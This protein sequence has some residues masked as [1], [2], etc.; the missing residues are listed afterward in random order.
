MLE[1]KNIHFCH[2]GNLAFQ[3][4][5]ISFSLDE[6]MVMCLL[7][8][9]GAGKT[10]LLNLIFGSL[11]K[12][13]GEIFIHQRP[14]EKRTLAGIRQE[15]ALVGEHQ[16]CFTGIS[17]EENIDIL[18]NLYESFDSVLFRKLCQN[19]SLPESVMHK[20]VSKLSTGQAKNWRLRLPFQ[21]SRSYFYWMNPLPV[22]MQ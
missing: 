6:G 14:L 8:K 1:V 13:G 12:R 21:E 19:L 17:I 20:S 18:S 16:W 22:W 5:N 4:R 9:N 15:M 2:D 3:L 10:T 11:W 7:G